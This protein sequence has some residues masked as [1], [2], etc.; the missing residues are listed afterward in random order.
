[1]FLHIFSFPPW[2]K[3]DFPR[4]KFE[5]IKKKQKIFRLHQRK[6]SYFFFFFPIY[7]KLIFSFSFPI[8]SSSLLLVRP[9]SKNPRRAHKIRLC[10][11]FCVLFSSFLFAIF[12]FFQ[13]LSIIFP[14]LGAKNPEKPH[15]MRS[16]G[17][18][19][20]SLYERPFCSK[21][22]QKSYPNHEK[23]PFYAVSRVWEKIKKP[24]V[25]A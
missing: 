4:R 17:F 2:G 5:V 22:I 18:L 6:L 11:T 8:F 24:W 1:M 23:A 10:G 12:L 25:D 19:P 16:L 13:V 15:F 9:F 21:I 20:F 3:L 7:L 14:I